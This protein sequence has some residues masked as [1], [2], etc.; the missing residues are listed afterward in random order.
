L[1]RVYF[2]DRD[3]GKLFPEI[4]R[5]GGLEVERH[6]DHFGDKTPDEDWLQEI[7]KRG[8]IAITHNKR[9]R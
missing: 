3:L 2:T 9:I 5:A 8:W 1:T 6:A 7:G 4:L